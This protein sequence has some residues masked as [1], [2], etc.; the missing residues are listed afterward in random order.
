MSRPFHDGPYPAP[1]LNPKQAQ[2]R[3]PTDYENLLASALE[4][5]FGAGVWELPVLVE[6]LNAEGVKTPDGRDWT[7][8]RF[9][10]ELGR[11]G[12]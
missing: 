10:A 12:A 3:A 5:A 11:L 2:E 1:W 8:A 6:R 4:S 9:E 7:P